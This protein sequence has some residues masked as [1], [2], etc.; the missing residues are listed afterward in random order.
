[1]GMKIDDS[2]IAIQP[3]GA[4]VRLFGGVDTCLDGIRVES[5]AKLSGISLYGDDAMYAHLDRV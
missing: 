3:I 2:T 4:A 5:A 1:M